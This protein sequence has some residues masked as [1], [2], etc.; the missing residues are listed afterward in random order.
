MFLGLSYAPTR[1]VE[2]KKSDAFV[3]QY[4]N[5]DGLGIGTLWSKESL[6]VFNVP[7]IVLSMTLLIESQP[8]TL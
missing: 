5:I 6:V 4:S 1:G 7:R 2:S 8:S 3:H